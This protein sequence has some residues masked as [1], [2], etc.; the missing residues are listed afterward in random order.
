MLRGEITHGTI[1][2]DAL[3]LING[4][5]FHRFNILNQYL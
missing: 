4:E 5:N 2:D 3:A 1:R